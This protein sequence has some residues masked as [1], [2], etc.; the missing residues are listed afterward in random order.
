MLKDN[1]VFSWSDLTNLLQNWNNTV[2]V[3]VENNFHSTLSKFQGLE[4]VKFEYSLRLKV[5]CNDW[6]LAD[7]CPQAANHCALF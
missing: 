5:K 6:L 2:T 3:E 1:L 7:M 4:V